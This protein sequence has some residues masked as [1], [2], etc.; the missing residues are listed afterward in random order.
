M[1]SL[2]TA[3]AVGQRE[4]ACCSNGRRARSGSARS[5]VKSVSGA[6]GILPRAPSVVAVQCSAVHVQLLNVATLGTPYAHHCTTKG[7][8]RHEHVRWI[9]SCPS[10]VVGLPAHARARL[11][12]ICLGRAP[13]AQ[14]APGNVAAPSCSLLSLVGPLVRRLQRPRS[15]TLSFAR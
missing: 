2:A 1:A 8:V 15:A 9:A 7:N 13:C 14:W 11:Q 10:G 4:E 3:P 12:Q 5:S 6:L